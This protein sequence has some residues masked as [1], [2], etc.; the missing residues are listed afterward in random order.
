MEEHKLM[1][2]DRFVKQFPSKAKA[3]DALGVRWFVLHGWL[4]RTHYASDAR[5]EL[6][7]E[8]GVALPKR[9]R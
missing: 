1:P 5:R 8:R 9:P 4:K 3:A 6:A 2:L 7:A